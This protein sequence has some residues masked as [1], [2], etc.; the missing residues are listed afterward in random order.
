[1]ACPGN[2]GKLI[3]LAKFYGLKLLRAGGPMP[4]LTT[5]RA[6]T[7][8]RRSVQSDVAVVCSLQLFKSIISIPESFPVL[9]TDLGPLV[10]A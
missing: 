1:M 8:A 3:R 7:L 2:R 6:Q 4:Q 5:R 9:L 10:I